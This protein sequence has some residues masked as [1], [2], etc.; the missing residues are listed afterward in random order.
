[1]ESNLVCDLH[2]RKTSKWDS[3]LLITSMI[4]A[5]VGQHNVLLPINQNYSKIWWNSLLIIFFTFSSKNNCA[6]Q[7]CMKM[8]HRHTV[9]SHRYEVSTV[10]LHCLITSMGEESFEL[11]PLKSW[12]IV[13]SLD[14]NL[15]VLWKGEQFRNDSAFFWIR[16]CHMSSQGCWN[17]LRQRTRFVLLLAFC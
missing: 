15:D 6:R 1:M 10:L 14:L 3:D 4:S 17:S 5:Q 16:L 12:R 9:H 13:F 7:E 2:N 11:I 8:T